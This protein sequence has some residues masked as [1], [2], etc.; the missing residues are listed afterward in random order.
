MYPVRKS[1][2]LVPLDQW[3]QEDCVSVGHVLDIR[4]GVRVCLVPQI[5]KRYV[6]VDL[7]AF[8]LYLSVTL[9]L[10]HNTQKNK[11]VTQNCPCK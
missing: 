2:E 11:F 9:A 7:L 4:K 8:L 10:V 6:K 3:G 1:L 5:G